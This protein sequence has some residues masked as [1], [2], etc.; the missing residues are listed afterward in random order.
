MHMI[1]QILNI[2][3]CNKCYYI[4]QNIYKKIIVCNEEHIVGVGFYAGEY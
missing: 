3:V 2:K 4:E 1:W